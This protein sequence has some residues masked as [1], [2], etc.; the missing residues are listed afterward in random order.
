MMEALTIE[1]TDNP[2]G[3]IEGCSVEQG[4]KYCRLIVGAACKKWKSR[5]SDPVCKECDGK[6]GRDIKDHP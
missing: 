5:K 3:E 6:K 1:A 2:N 4:S